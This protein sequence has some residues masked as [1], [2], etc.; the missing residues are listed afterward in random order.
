MAIM[1]H[2]LEMIKQAVKGFFDR[3]NAWSAAEDA[4]NRA[5]KDLADVTSRRYAKDIRF[6]AEQLEPYGYD[7]T[8]VIEL[9]CLKV[10]C[11]HSPL[12]VKGELLMKL[13]ACELGK[14]A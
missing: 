11:G 13:D 4:R 8:L 3:M 10:E 6:L 7:P 9:A 12:E 1:K 14:R 2:L 5:V